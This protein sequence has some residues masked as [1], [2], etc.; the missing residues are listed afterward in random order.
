MKNNT[1]K[2]FRDA[3]S[4]GFQTITQE[5]VLN[6]YDHCLNYCH[7]QLEKENPI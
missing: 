2:S 6:M 7:K 5:N 4:A 1:A 3:I